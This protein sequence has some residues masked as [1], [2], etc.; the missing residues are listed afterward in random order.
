MAEAE[1]PARSSSWRRL[2]VALPVA[3]SVGI[4]AWLLGSDEIDLRG[5]LAVVDLPS[6]LLL[7]GAITVYVTIRCR[8]K[9]VDLCQRCMC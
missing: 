7:A 4:F 2:R 8:Q 9:S 5:A 6:L 1:V 3:V